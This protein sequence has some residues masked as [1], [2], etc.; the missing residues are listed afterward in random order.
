MFQFTIGDVCSFA[1]GA[2]LIRMAYPDRP[3]VE[4]RANAIICLLED[5]FRLVREELGLIVSREAIS[6]KGY[7]L[8]PPKAQE[9]FI[10]LLR[11][12]SPEGEATFS[13]ALREHKIEARRRREMF[14]A[15]LRAYYARL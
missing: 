8:L 4:K 7:L 13:R 5:V 14:D 12:M 9:K 1:T 2:S 11:V 10:A 15:Q 6:E 3:D